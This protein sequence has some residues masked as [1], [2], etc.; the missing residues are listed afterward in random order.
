MKAQD[1]VD[2]WSAKPT[3]QIVSIG[4]DFAIVKKERYSTIEEAEEHLKELNK[5][6]D[7]LDENCPYCKDSKLEYIRVISCPNP[8]AYNY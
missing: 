8:C 5:V 7:C 2:S 4:D 3:N 1:L 6:D